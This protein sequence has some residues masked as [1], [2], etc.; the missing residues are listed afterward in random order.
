MNNIYFYLNTYLVHYDVLAMQDG[1]RLID[2]YLGDWFIRKCMWASK[3]SINNNCSTFKKFYKCMFENGFVTKDDY[4]YVV[5]LIK[6][7]KED[8]LET[9]RQYDSGEWY[10]SSFSFKIK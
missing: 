3:E 8:W 4:E 5:Y 10:G 6:E 2:D 7:E 1:C 9:L